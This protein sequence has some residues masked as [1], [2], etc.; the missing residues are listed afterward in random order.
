MMKQYKKILHKPDINLDIWYHV[1]K[2]YSFMNTKMVHEKEVSRLERIRCVCKYFQT[3]IDSDKEFN[4]IRTFFNNKYETRSTNHMNVINLCGS[5][6][7]LVS[8]NTS[9]YCDISQ[10]L[11]DIC[12]RNTWYHPYLCEIKYTFLKKG[13]LH[14]LLPKYHIS[15]LNMIEKGMSLKTIRDISIQLFQV[16]RY[17]HKNGISHGN[18]APKRIFI[19]LSTSFV[20]S[21]RLMDFTFSTYLLPSGS[22]NWL[23]SRA[24]PEL[25]KKRTKGTYG[26]TNDMWA[27]GH[28]IQEM[29]RTMTEVNLT[30][31]EKDIFDS[32]TERLLTVDP[33]KRLTADEALRVLNYTPIEGK[34]L[35]P[36]RSVETCTSPVWT[37]LILDLSYASKAFNIPFPNYFATVFILR[38]VKNITFELGMSCLLLV[39]M[40]HMN[41]NLEGF[42]KN[43]CHTQNCDSNVTEAHIMDILHKTEFNLLYYVPSPMVEKIK[44]YNS[45]FPTILCEKNMLKYPKKYIEYIIYTIYEIIKGIH[46]PIQHMQLISTTIANLPNAIFYEGTSIKDEEYTSTLN[47]CKHRLFL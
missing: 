24:A 6:Y 7:Q 14:I 31:S 4:T 8:L 39:S 35:T 43:L 11:R 18:L 25:R 9:I 46:F 23:P 27:L 13:F 21:V 45:I 1:L 37:N 38:T 16:M 40:L 28:I 36:N 34:I 42:Q 32:V 19:E 33:H 30:Q 26:N 22:I 3:T 44:D 15:L 2:S 41:G 20:V 12:I 47:K 5:E 29:T 10:E 17:L